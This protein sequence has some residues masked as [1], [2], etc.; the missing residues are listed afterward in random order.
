M[1]WMDASSGTPRCYV[2]S[3]PLGGG[4][5]EPPQLLNPQSSGAEGNAKL[6]ATNNEL[7]A[8]WEQTLPPSPGAP[9]AEPSA[10]TSEHGHAAPSGSRAIYFS[11]GIAAPTVEG[12]TLNWDAPRPIALKDGAFQS[13]PVL[14]TRPGGHIFAAWNE[15]D[16][17]GKRIVVARMSQEF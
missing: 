8:V 14:A 15:L 17:Q 16:E 1:A 4:N 2:T 10:A 7:V 6:L 5:F 13:R 9:S 3:K 12:S 11:A